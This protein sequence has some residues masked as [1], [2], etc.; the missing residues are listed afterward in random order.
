MSQAGSTMELGSVSTDVGRVTTDLGKT[1]APFYTL[2][3]GAGV[4]GLVMAKHVL[5]ANM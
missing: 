5:I 4:Q 2:S 3:H 1:I